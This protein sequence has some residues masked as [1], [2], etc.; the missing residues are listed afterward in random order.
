MIEEKQSFPI[1]N[2]GFLASLEYK[3]FMEFMIAYINEMDE[4]DKGD[5]ADDYEC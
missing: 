3:S 5:S 4:S 1:K 2:T